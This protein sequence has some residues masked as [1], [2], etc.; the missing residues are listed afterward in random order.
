MNTLGIFVKQ[1]KP[2]FV[3][4]RLAADWGAD[5]AAELYSAFI[6]D[7]VDR[8]RQTADRRVLCYTPNDT[9]AA[10]CFCSIAGNDYQVWAQPDVE[11]GGRIAAFAKESLQSGNDRVVIIGSD[12]PTL[13]RD[14]VELAFEQLE[15][16]DCTVGPATDGGHYLIGQRL[17]C[18]RLFQQIEWGSIRV[19][20]QTVKRIA[21]LGASLALLPVWYDIDTSDDLQL[22]RGHLRA[23]RYTASSR[24]F[25]KTEQ[26]LGLYPFDDS[27]S[28]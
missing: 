5:H 14:Y 25:E 22:L 26:V 23:M 11:L 16:H 18:D 21:E 13:P 6:D 15:F 1:P 12:S 19:L 17:R 9:A 20:D 4:T 7:L 8:F 27:V 10:D 3:K 2:G 28:L 24:T